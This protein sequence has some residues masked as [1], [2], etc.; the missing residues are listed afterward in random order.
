LG[1]TGKRRGPRAKFPFS[2]LLPRAEQRR[3][4][5]RRRRP[6]PAGRGPGRL[7]VEGKRERERR[8]SH[9]RPH[10]GPGWSEEARPREPAGGGGAT[11]CGGA[12]G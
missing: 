9:P 11:G 7:G 1:N 3:G 4:R 10:L 12:A 2:L 5:E 6:H 8:G